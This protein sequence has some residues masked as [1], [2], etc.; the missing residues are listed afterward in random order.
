MLQLIRTM[1]PLR[2]TMAMGAG[3]IAFVCSAP[4]V[5]SQTT[6]TWNQTGSASYSTAANWT[7][8]RSSPQNTDVLVI[9]GATTPSPTVQDVATQTI[10]RL[11]VIG[12]ASVVM[13]QSSTR[14]L[15]LTA[16]GVPALEIAAGSSLTLS[17]VRTLE[18]TLAAAATATIAGNLAFADNANK[19]NAATAGAITFAAG[20]SFSTLAAFRNNPFGATG[21]A[22]VAVFQS[23]STYTHNAG[24]DPFGLT[25]PASKVTFQPGSMFVARSATGFATDGRTYGNLTIDN[26]TSVSNSGSGSFQFQTLQVNAGSSFTHTGSGSSSIS[27]TGDITSSGTGNIALTSGS[28]GIGIGGGGTRTVG[29][30]GGSGSISLVGNVTV[31]N[32]TTLAASRAIG[33]TS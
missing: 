9:N 20:S 29:G 14:I 21:T 28:G 7:P 11:R 1:R 33:V 3:L 2:Q 12:G 30:G 13:T 25:A 17:G 10:G 24:G 19:L 22:N 8:T 16:T 23:G 18:I 15:T 31:A 5:W 6:Y 26:N 27:I 32:G 4:S